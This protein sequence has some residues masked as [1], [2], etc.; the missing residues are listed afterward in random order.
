M[1]PYPWDKMDKDSQIHKVNGQ[2]LFA[3]EPWR[4]EEGMAPR[5][6]AMQS[7]SA[8][9]SQSMVISKTLPKHGYGDALCRALCLISV[10]VNDKPRKLALQCLQE[11]IS[12]ILQSCS[13][14]VLFNT[15]SRNANKCKQVKFRTYSK[16]EDCLNVEHDTTMFLDIE[17]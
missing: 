8:R 6:C 4:K 14:S 2:T 16:V 9:H 5:R 15:K 10:L 12:G 11:L 1:L 3:W 17:V 7:S 13:E